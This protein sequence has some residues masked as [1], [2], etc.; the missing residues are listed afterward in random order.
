MQSKPTIAFPRRRNTRLRPPLLYAL[1]HG[2]VIE[3]DKLGCKCAQSYGPKG[4]LSVSRT[5]G[6]TKRDYVP[7]ADV[8][9]VRQCLI[10][11][12][13]TPEILDELCAINRKRLRRRE[14]L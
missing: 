1:L 4:Y 13:R 3:R 14:M 9:Q 10:P 6:R 2:S 8:V 5:G 12:C 11:D 7:Q